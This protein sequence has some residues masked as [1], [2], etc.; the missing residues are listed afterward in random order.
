ML[1]YEYL[2]VLGSDFFFYFLCRSIVLIFRWCIYLFF[3]FCY[4]SMMKT[5]MEGGSQK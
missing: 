5:V 4:G 1:S 3:F 2:L